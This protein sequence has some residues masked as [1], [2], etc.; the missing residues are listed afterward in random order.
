MTERL[1][2]LLHDEAAALVPPAPPA[3]AILRL[4]KRRRRRTRAATALAGATVLVLVGVG[5]VAAVGRGSG[6]GP[7][8]AALAEFERWGAVAVGRDVYIGDTHV[9]VPGDIS[10]MYY[11]ADGV[12]IRSGGAYQIVRADGEVSSIDVDIPDRIPGFEPD[13]TRFAYA[14]AAGADRWEVVVHDTAT[15]EELARVEV[16]GPAYGGWEAPPVAIDGDLAWIHLAGHWA[17][18]NWRTGDV[19]T[20]PGTGDTYELANGVYAVQAGP[21]ANRGAGDWEVRRW[22][23]GGLVGIA[24]LPHNW[25]AFFSPDGRFL[26]AFSQGRADADERARIYEPATGRSRIVDATD[27]GWTPS[28]DL[29]IVEQDELRVCTAMTGECRTRSFERGAGDLRIGG[30]PYE[31]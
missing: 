22:S 4:G 14:E 23:D 26:R 1:A 17:E 10:A 16:A 5:V 3:A 20:V 19:R 2:T 15:D 29:L 13:S 8:A 21:Y 6:P 28:G 11:S 24:A 12:V 18:V 7:D 27:F 9:R 30:N 31:S 25:Y